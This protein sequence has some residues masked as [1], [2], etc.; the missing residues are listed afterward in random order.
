MVVTE[1]AQTTLS[2]VEAIAHATDEI[3]VAN[4]IDNLRRASTMPRLRLLVIGEAGSG[5]ATVA[6]L[7]LGRPG[8]L[9]A[10]AVPRPATRLEIEHGVPDRVTAVNATGEVPLLPTPLEDAVRSAATSGQYTAVKVS[11][12]APLLATTTLVLED[13]SIERAQDEWLRLLG[14]THYVLLVLRAVALLSERERRFLADVLEPHFGL[15]RVGL[16]VN[17]ADLV[18]EDER[19]ELAQRLRRFLG[20][21]EAQPAIIVRGRGG[22]GDESLQ[23]L[24][25]H[26]LQ[27]GYGALRQ[28]SLQSG[29]MQSVAA[30]RSR[31][32]RRAALLDT[33]DAALRELA[34]T[35]D[36][37][38]GWLQTRVARA[39]QRL[40]ADV[41]TLIAEPLLRDVEDF[42]QIL[43]GQLE[44]QLTEVDD[45]NAVRRHLPGYV[46]HLWGTFLEGR[47]S[48]ARARLAAEVETLAADV[49][50]DLA[51]AAGEATP[52]RILLG[53][54]V[55]ADSVF[56]RLFL[57]PTRGS[58]LGSAAASVVQ[59]FG[60][61]LTMSNLG[62]AA[63]ALGLGHLMRTM[64]EPGQRAADQKA[65]LAALRE[66][67]TDIE[68]VVKNQLQ[69]TL[70][71]AVG[72]IKGAVAEAYEQGAASLRTR[73]EAAL[74][75]R[76]ELES[77]RAVL[78][79]ALAQLAAVGQE[80]QQ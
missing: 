75:Q 54:S 34:A 71:A 39:Q 9:P 61:V 30:L 26:D 56:A 17:Q 22:L 35:L 68:K 11:A 77:Q 70:G 19:A 47:L 15:G 10:S 41:A 66:G 49:Q 12:N 2:A 40:E 27:V 69:Q 37:R 74:L 3:A 64:F 45:L 38:S 46:E 53:D 25:G 33:D 65:L 36:D 16:V 4:A 48:R 42:T 20:P 5:R 43:K 13:L 78:E 76:G 50:R 59:V 72:E 6:N 58:D 32:E 60:L 52:S 21:Y 51:D 44:T 8:L 79:Q 55:A 67:L 29:A 14:E 24:V 80:V 7:L 18:D 1:D 73:V 62:T 31:L 57:P 23:T 28:A 63:A